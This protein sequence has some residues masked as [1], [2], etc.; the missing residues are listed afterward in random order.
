MRSSVVETISMDI[1]QLDMQVLKSKTW[2]LAVTT[3]HPTGEGV[4]TEAK[5]RRALSDQPHTISPLTTGNGRDTH[6]G[7][8]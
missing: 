1:L 8:Q 4:C 7:S 5:I 3:D 2:P 6:K